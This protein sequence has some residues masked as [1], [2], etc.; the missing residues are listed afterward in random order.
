MS[1]STYLSLQKKKKISEKMPY[2]DPQKQ[3]EA[4]GFILQKYEKE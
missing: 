1:F 3:K 2:K 4:N